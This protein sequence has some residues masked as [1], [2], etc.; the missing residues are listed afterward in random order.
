VNVNQRR[1]DEARDGLPMTP[2]SVSRLRRTAETAANP[3][4]DRN[5]RRRAPQ[6]RVQL[7]T[8][9]SG[10]GAS[11]RHSHAVRM[12]RSATVCARVP[13]FRA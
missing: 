2:D 9:L 8:T 6:S 12:P 4:A 7:T 13:G 3:I 1:T 11:I 10:P 5:V